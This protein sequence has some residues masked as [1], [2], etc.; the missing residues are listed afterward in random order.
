MKNLTVWNHNINEQQKNP[1]NPFIMSYQIKQ[2]KK[3]HVC[4]WILVAWGFHIG[5]H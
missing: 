1:V 5:Q 3:S 2:T 4:D